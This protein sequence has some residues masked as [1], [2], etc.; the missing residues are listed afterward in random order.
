MLRFVLVCTLITGLG[1]RALADRAP[2]HF[3][4]PPATSTVAPALDRATLRARL[5]AARRAN[6]AAFRAYRDGGVFPSN[7]Y[8]AS[9]LNV[10]RDRDGHLCAAATIIDR[11]GQHDLVARV[12]EQNN[13]I[14]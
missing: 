13:F 6:L 9:K 14:R 4:R 10:W 2:A 5:V 1:P 11:S 3:A 12:A 8:R 7:T